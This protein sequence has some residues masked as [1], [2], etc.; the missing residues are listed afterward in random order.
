MKDRV[1]TQVINGAVR[2]EQLDENG[3]SLGYSYWKRADEPSEE[4]TPYNKNN[5]LTDETATALGL[6][7]GRNPVPNDAF[8]AI[9]GQTQIGDIKITT[10][11]IN[12]TTWIQCDGRIIRRSEYPELYDLLPDTRDTFS[13]KWESRTF[14]EYGCLPVKADDG[15]IYFVSGD[16]VTRYDGNLRNPVTYTP[17]KSGNIKYHAQCGYWTSCDASNVY[18]SN[19]CFKTA[20]NVLNFVYPGPAAENYVSVHDFSFVNNTW[21]LTYIYNSFSYGMSKSTSL[22]NAFETI[23]DI[24]KEFG[25]FTYTTAEGEVY[26][27]FGHLYDVRFDKKGGAVFDIALRYRYSDSYTQSFTFYTNDITSKSP[28]PMYPNVNNHYRAE[29]LQYE[30]N[31][32]SI[33]AYNTE[34]VNSTSTVHVLMSGNLMRF[35]KEKVLRRGRSY[36]L[37]YDGQYWYYVLPAYSSGNDVYLYRRKGIDGADELAAAGTLLY[38]YAYTTFIVSDDIF[39]FKKDNVYFVHY[40]EATIPKPDLGSEIYKTYIKAKEYTA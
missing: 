13:T 34:G 36:Q 24:E 31:S 23:S 3:N 8:R 26:N 32:D 18:Y 25:K 7:V 33:I 39:V 30:P 29:Y 6:D 1:P 5:V 40:N 17:L 11:D 20:I 35:G 12:D 9:A 2:M 15:Y 21:Y 4:G 37:Q 27:Y 28:V 19:D 38:E 22:T 14:P 10:R 16:S